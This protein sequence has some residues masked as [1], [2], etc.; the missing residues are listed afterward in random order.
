MED[1]F[2]RFALNTEDPL[3]NF[4]IGFKYHELGHWASAA[5]HYLRCAERTDD[6]NFAYECLIRC[7]YCFKS[8]Q[9]R[10]FT[11]VHF[12]KHALT[13]LPK[14]PEAYFILAKYH[15]QKGEWYD[16]YTITS[17]ALEVC[18]FDVTPLKTFIEYPGKY[19]LLYLKALSGWYWEKIDQT[20][21][22]FIDLRDKHII[23]PVY[24]ESVVNNLKNLYGIE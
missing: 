5:S 23:D 22:I 16:C 6:L 11:A 14:R 7:Y 13:V 10:D 1:V 19:G 12:L 18:D 3:T 24:K 15:E 9:N 21:D 4:D 8:M 17:I 20:K 2:T